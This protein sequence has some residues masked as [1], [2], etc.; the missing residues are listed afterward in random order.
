M[1]YQGLFELSII[2][3]YYQN[4]VCPDLNIEPTPECRQILARH[5]LLVKNKVNGI[6]VIVPV[7]ETGQPWLELT[8]DL[9]F[10]FL[11]KIKNSSFLDF[12]HI[13]AK[14]TRAPNERYIYW[15]SNQT[16]TGIGVS[17]L[18]RTLY[19]PKTA[20]PKLPPQD[21][22]N[23]GVITIYN[24]S[25]LPKVFL[26]KSS[27]QTSEYQISWQSKRQHWYYYLITEPETNGDVFLIADAADARAEKIKFTKNEIN[28]SDR[29]QLYH[30]FTERFAGKQLYL[31]SS[32]T[33][34]NCQEKGRK[35]IQ[36]LKQKQN[37]KSKPT[38]WI[39]H[40]PN[41]PNRTGIQVINALKFV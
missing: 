26:P 21:R 14:F 40:L 25:S 4:K 1:N 15:F 19:D 29:D 13:N 28:Q 7:T 16:I 5:R 31:F 30:V 6:Q 3:D 41:P 2:H 32:E 10:T 35:H 37:G 12:T 22:N 23:L 8:D 36:L 34:I 27:N 9:V 39:N 17:S 11:L 33:E 24:N 20:E 38:V 18:E